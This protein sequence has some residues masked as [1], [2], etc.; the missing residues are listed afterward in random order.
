M[1]AAPYIDVSKSFVYYFNSDVKCPTFYR[2]SYE[3]KW[4]LLGRSL[5]LGLQRS[6]YPCILTTALGT[7]NK[8]ELGHVLNF[9]MLLAN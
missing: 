5:V 8:R 7:I 1:V 6:R 4:I 9:T 2:L 3:S